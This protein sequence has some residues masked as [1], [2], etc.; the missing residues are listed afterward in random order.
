MFLYYDFQ[1]TM[2]LYPGYMYCKGAQARWQKRLASGAGSGA[3]QVSP[4]YPDP[5]TY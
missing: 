2:W 4:I 3:K 5:L 1:A